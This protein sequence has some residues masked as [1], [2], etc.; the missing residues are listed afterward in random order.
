MILNKD[1]TKDFALDGV[2]KVKENARTSLELGKKGDN[3]V[4]SSETFVEGEHNGKNVTH[5]ISEINH[6]RSKNEIVS[7]PVIEV[8][9]KEE[10]GTKVINSNSNGKIKDNLIGAEP[11]VLNNSVKGVP[12]HEISSVKG[13]FYI[14]F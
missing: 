5:T 3:F 9:V 6:L 4:N 7:I 12:E 2:E 8:N 1:K 14:S 10:T 11:I 13:N